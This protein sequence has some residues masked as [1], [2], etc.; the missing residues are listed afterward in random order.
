ME[1]FFVIIIVV[2]IFSLIINA[3][4]NSVNEKDSLQNSLRDYSNKNY[5]LSDEIKKV[6]TEIAVFKKRELSQIEWNKK[7]EQIIKNNESEKT[8][9]Q[10][11]LNE[12]EKENADLIIKY[13]KLNDGIDLLKKRELSQI[14]WEE[15]Q[16]Q[17]KNNFLQEINDNL[18]KREKAYKWIAPV[19]ADIRLFLKERGRNPDELISTKRSYSTNVRVNILVNEKKKL[20]EENALL[21]YQIEYIKALI[22][23][24]ED[25]VEYDEYKAEAEDADNSY[26]F[27]SKDEYK[28]LSDT[29]KNIRALE[30]YKKRPKKN[31][32]LGRDFERYIGFIY[33]E[34]GYEV[35]YFGIEKK[36]NDLG[37]DLIVKKDG[38]TIII[39]CKYWSKHKTIHEK[40]IMQLFGTLVKYRI[41]NPN[42]QN[43]QGLFVSHTQLS[44][45][46]KEFAKA[47]SIEIEENVELGEFPLIKCN[48]GHD[49]EYGYRTKIYHLPMDQQYDVT[50]V[51]KKDGDF[52]AFTIEEA[53]SKGYTRAHKWHGNS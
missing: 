37:R 8:I 19:I 44:D 35:E 14:E 3:I 45:V 16:E 46:A 31:W 41:D 40:H 21:K 52:Y 42:E 39:Q 15:K 18:S 48:N 25:I 2:I 17:I 7:Q 22:P 36:L 29:E 33:E 13:N 4:K 28:L 12:S 24:T 11:R 9:L 49:K 51:N 30:Y 20:L 5:L 32:E 47:L 1:I 10:N 38:S 50:K 6:N 27:L 53:E 43:V 34:N 23:E 26:K